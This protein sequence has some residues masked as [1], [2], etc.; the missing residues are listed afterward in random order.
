MFS[1]GVFPVHGID[2][3]VSTKGV[4]ELESDMVTIAELET[5]SIS[6]DG[7]VQEWSPL[8]QKGWKRRLMTGKSISVTCNG[9]RN[10]GDPGNDYIA[11]LMDKTGQDATTTCSIT[12][13][14]GDIFKMNCVIDIKEYI[15]GES[16]DV[17]PLSFD[18]LSD[19]KPSYQPK[20]A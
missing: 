11:G 12:F 19:G 4:T 1:K 14:N 15:G 7:V 16:T 5:F 20:S 10:V 17:A 13:P 9:K 3:K 8:E 2:I 18:A 6:V